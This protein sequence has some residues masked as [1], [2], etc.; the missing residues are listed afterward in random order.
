MAYRMQFEPIVAAAPQLLQGALNTLSLS[1]QSIALG[2]SIGLVAAV[3]RVER[4]GWPNR[5]V[6]VYVEVFRNTPLLVQLFLIYFGLPLVGLRLSANG[7]AVFAISLNLGAY[8]TEIIRAGLL[9]IPKT[10]VEAGLA[11]GMS[12][13]QVVRYI[14]VVPAL[15]II[16]PALTGQ[17]TLTLLG[18]SIASAISATELTSAGSMIESANFRSLE[19]FL[20]I[21]AIYIC[22]TFAFRFVYWLIGLWLFHRKKPP[23]PSRAVSASTVQAGA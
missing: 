19:T 4:P 15:R 20:T 18:T 2:V 14:I 5:L 12:R 1:A 10:Q 9:A 16:Y 23:K 6:G 13:L 17:L 11:L 3:V 8:A 22:M 21:A 7:A